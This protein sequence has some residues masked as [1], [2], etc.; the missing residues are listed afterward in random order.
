MFTFASKHTPCL[1]TSSLCTG[2]LRS[3]ASS[4]RLYLVTPGIAAS[5][6]APLPLDPG[7][8]RSGGDL[9]TRALPRL[10]PPPAPPPHA[11]PATTLQAPLAAGN[12]SPGGHPG[13]RATA[14]ASAA[15]NYRADGCC[16]PL[17][18]ASG[19]SACTRSAATGTNC[20]ATAT[21]TAG[22]RMTHEV[23]VMLLFPRG[24]APSD[25]KE[26]INIQQRPLSRNCGREK[27]WQME[28]EE[29]EF[30][31]QNGCGDI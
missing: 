31:D 27:M 2:S 16:S 10:L 8:F 18:S 15:S 19:E 30:V 6:P 26:E 3:C 13:R 20:A 29:V 9:Q 24:A 4:T 17:S 25:L 12:T 7:V 14:A 22:V 11:P 28:I 21:T 1:N 23:R 5:V